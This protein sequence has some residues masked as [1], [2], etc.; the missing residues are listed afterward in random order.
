M[1]VKNN[2]KKEIIEKKESW[3]I[4]DR[5]EIYK[6]D[7]VIYDTKE[8]KDIPQTIFKWRDELMATK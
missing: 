3:L 5:Y 1:V 8:A 4:N 7:G 2:M 6:D